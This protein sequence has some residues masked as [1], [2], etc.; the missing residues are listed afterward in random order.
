MQIDSIALTLR[1]RSTWE[2]CDLGIRLLQ[3]RMRSVYACYLVVAVPAFLACLATY[4][5]A[6]WLPALAL[7]L[8]KPWLDQAIL[9]ALSRALFGERTG[10]RDLWAGRRL[11]L[12]PNLP[13][14]LLLRLSASRSFKLPIVQLEGLAGPARRERVRQLTRRH[15]SVAR[16]MTLAFANAELALCSS[17]LMLRVALAPHISG[18]EG[19]WLTGLA[20]SNAGLISSIAYALAVAFLEPFYVA[21]GFGLYVNRRVELEAWDIE[22][23]FRR[24]FAH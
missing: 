23:E 24:A 5:L 6:P 9:F 2:G 17:V 16:G 21:A 11:L 10:P 8:A 20:S 19:G 22:Q 1:P 15:R 7:W 4:P 18:L 14:L 13:A 3:S 12:R